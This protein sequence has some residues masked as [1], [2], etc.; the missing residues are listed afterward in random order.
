MHATFW[1]LQ[2]LALESKGRGVEGASMEETDYPSFRM[3]RG[4]EGLV[5]DKQKPPLRTI[6]SEGICIEKGKVRNGNSVTMISI[7]QF[8]KT[9][10]LMILYLQFLWLARSL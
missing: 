4:L 3:L 6:R 5:V 10:N 7:S 1:L 2:E 8:P 9:I